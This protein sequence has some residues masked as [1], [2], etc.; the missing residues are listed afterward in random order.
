M[1]GLTEAAFSGDGHQR[2]AVEGEHIGGVVADL[3]LKPGEGRR[4]IP[5]AGRISWSSCA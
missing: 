3:V 5:A 1:R 2:L 4:A